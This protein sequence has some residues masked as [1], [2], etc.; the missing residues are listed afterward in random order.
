VERPVTLAKMFF[1]LKKNQDHE[2]KANIKI[3]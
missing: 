2:M 1:L 3:F